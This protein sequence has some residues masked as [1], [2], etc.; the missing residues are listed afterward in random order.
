MNKPETTP[1]KSPISIQ[2]DG[3]DD[4]KN[5]TVLCCAGHD[6]GVEL[7]SYSW[8]RGGFK[9][10][11]GEIDFIGTD[12]GKVWM[13]MDALL[14]LSL[15]QLFSLFFF[16]RVSRHRP[17]PPPL[18]PRQPSCR[19]FKSNQWDGTNLSSIPYRAVLV[20]IAV[21]PSYSRSHCVCA[22]EVKI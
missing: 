22:A 14:E 17:L 21:L 4:L 6:G 2:L 19:L 11:R 15:H 1:T 10:Q 20:V 5:R 12:F 16:P 3:W 7:P 18:R 13:A 9:I 8:S